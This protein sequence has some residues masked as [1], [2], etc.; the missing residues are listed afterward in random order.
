MKK[1]FTYIILIVILGCTIQKDN[2]FIDYLNEQE[3]SAKDYILNLFKTADLVIICERHHRDISQYKLI[4]ELMQ[5]SVFQNQVGNIITE[6]GVVNSYDSINNFLLSSNLSEF[7]QESQLL[8]IIRN[9]DYSPAWT[10][11][12]YP[13]LLEKVYLLNQKLPAEKKIR[14]IPSDMKFDWYRCLTIQQYKD[15]DNIPERDTLIANNILSWYSIQNAKKKALVILNFRHAF[16]V[17]T[18]WGTNKN[19]VHHNVGR[20]LKDALG[21]KVASVYLNGLAY[22]N[23]YDKYELIQEGKWDAYF[24]IVK[25]DKIGFDFK[26]NPFGSSKFDLIPFGYSVDSFTYEDIFTGMIFYEPINNHLMQ[27]GWKNFIDSTFSTEF[28]RRVNIYSQAT[29]GQK[30]DSLEI[31]NYINELNQI[32]SYKYDNLESLLIKIDSIKN[33]L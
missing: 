20:Y 29:L 15:F 24:S 8:N 6:V 5:D 2:Q 11:S 9:I 22:P 14:L 17:D 21:V 26:G 16:L 30:I 23:E 31:L 32:S 18:H 7:E 27:D 10:P 19:E 12:N 33:D 4:V 3:V 1:T 25:K 28:T 13:Q